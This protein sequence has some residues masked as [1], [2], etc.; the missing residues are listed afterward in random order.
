MKISVIQIKLSKYTAKCPETG[1][2]LA[3]PGYS[4]HHSVRI[5]SHVKTLMAWS[6]IAYN[7]RL[8]VGRVYSYS[9][10]R[11]SVDPRFMVCGADMAGEI[12]FEEVF[13]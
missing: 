5:G 4:R 6:Y 2:L 7:Q 10:M 9:E 13:I 1:E 12:Q 8:P 11:Q 3:R